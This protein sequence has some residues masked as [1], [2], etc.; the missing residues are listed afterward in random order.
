MCRIADEIR[1]PAF[2]I[3]VCQVLAKLVPTAPIIPSDD[4]LARCFSD[5]A[6]CGW[7]KASPFFY[8]GK[9]RLQTGNECLRIS[10]DIQQNLK[11]VTMPLL[12]CHGGDDTVTDINASRDLVARASSEKKTLKEYDG[13]WHGLLAE[14]DRLRVITDCLAFIREICQ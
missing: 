11:E 13:M 14:P 12:V 7:C 3:S 1:P 8:S 4:I 2:V 6:L 5:P 10:E 9:P